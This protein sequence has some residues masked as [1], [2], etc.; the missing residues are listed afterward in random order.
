VCINAQFKGPVMTDAP[1]YGKPQC[2]QSTI[3]QHTVQRGVKVSELPGNAGGGAAGTK[4]GD[5]MLFMWTTPMSQGLSD[6][7]LRPRQPVCPEH[8]KNDLWSI[9]SSTF[10]LF[11]ND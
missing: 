5:G 4:I 11:N 10:C 2:Y 6:S 1:T 7:H 9:V 8:S 3:K